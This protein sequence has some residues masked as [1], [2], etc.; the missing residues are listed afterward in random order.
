MAKDFDSWMAK[1]DSHIEKVIGLSSSDLS[2]CNYSSWFEDGITPSRAARMA[3][4]ENG[5]E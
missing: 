5:M 2:D 3:L 1:V 4:R